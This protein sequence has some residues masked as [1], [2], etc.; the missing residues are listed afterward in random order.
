M[1]NN[2]NPLLTTIQNGVKAKL[3]AN[4]QE[5][6][7]KVTIAGMKLMF[8]PQSH[9][10]LVKGLKQ[11]PNMTDNVGRC[12]AGAVAFMFQKSNHTMPVKVV[13]PA[14]IYLM[15]EMLDFLEKAGKIKITKDVV[16]QSTKAAAATLMKKF[17]VNPG[18]VQK[19]KTQNAQP[20]PTAKPKG[21][22]N[23][24]QGAA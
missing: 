18:V 13:A 2:M 16:A 5:P 17:G 8:D 10:L 22:I 24:V 20:A 19:A 9:D 7:Q 3:P 6:F 21:I 11:T 4:M 14:S 12:A 15:C 1:A 23:Q